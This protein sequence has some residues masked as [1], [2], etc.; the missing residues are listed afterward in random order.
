MWHYSRGSGLHDGLLD[1]SG[2]GVDAKGAVDG[3]LRRL[4]PGGLSHVQGASI[5]ASEGGGDALVSFEGTTQGVPAHLLGAL[6]KTPTDHL[7]ELVGDDGDEQM[8][9]GTDGLVV[10]DGQ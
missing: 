8:A 4:G 7:H 1:A 9:F 5:G 3:L 6:A 10:E 2:F